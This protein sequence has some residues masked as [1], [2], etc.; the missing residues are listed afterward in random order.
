MTA[1]TEAAAAKT[2]D[3]EDAAL[4]TVDNLRVHFG[5]TEV[6]HGISFAAY[7]GRCLAIVGESGSG[8]SVTARTLVGL[9]GRNARVDADR[10][11]LGNK[12]L[13]RSSERDWRAIRGREIGFI[14]QDALVSLDQLRRVGDEV[15]EPLKPSSPSTSCAGSATR[16]PSR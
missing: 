10:I 16:W 15:A 3:T 2:E 9:T 1:T 12:D 4:L 14:L 8:K 7:P 11:S 5:E 13:L 6:V